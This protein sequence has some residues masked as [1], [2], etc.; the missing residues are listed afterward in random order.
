MHGLRH[1][2]ISQISQMVQRP[3]EGPKNTSEY[4]GAWGHQLLIGDICG[5]L[6]HA[7]RCLRNQAPSLR[8]QV[9]QNTASGSGRGPQEAQLGSASAGSA[10]GAVGAAESSSAMALKASAL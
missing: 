3:S 1:P 4:F 8:P 7:R 5:Q 10:A 6:V 9:E 2:Q